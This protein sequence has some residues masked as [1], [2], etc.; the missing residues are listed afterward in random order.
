[1]I[2]AITLYAL[3][4][5]IL[6]CSQQEASILQYIN[7]TSEP[8]FW[9][10]TNAVE[11]CEGYNGSSTSHVTKCINN[12]AFFLDEDHE[13][14]IFFKEDFINISHNL[15]LSNTPYL[16]DTDPITSRHRF[17]TEKV[18]S[19]FHNIDSWF[20]QILKKS[21]LYTNPIKDNYLREIIIK[22]D[23][24]FSSVVTSKVDNSNSID[25]AIYLLDRITSQTD[26]SRVTLSLSG[27]LLYKINQQITFLTNIQQ[28]SCH[29]IGCNRT[30]FSSQVLTQ[31][32]YTLALSANLENSSNSNIAVLSRAMALLKQ[33]IDNDSFLAELS[34]ESGVDLKHI[35]DLSNLDLDKAPHYIRDFVIAFTS[36]LSKVSYMQAA[37]SYD[38]GKRTDISFGFAKDSLRQIQSSLA[39]YIN[40]NRFVL[41]QAKAER[42]D[43]LQRVQDNM[44]SHEARTILLNRQR[45]MLYE[46]S[47]KLSEME[48]IQSQVIEH[49]LL[50]NKYINDLKNLRVKIDGQEFSTLKHV[51]DINFTMSAQ[52]LK[53]DGDSNLNLISLKS[54]TNNTP[55]S[56]IYKMTVTGQ[57]SPICALKKNNFDI[58]DTLTG[59]EGYMLHHSRSESKIESVS[60]ANRTTKYQDNSQTSNLCIS[61]VYGTPLS[62]ISGSAVG[63]SAT[64]CINYSKGKRTEETQDNSS[65]N[66]NS[67]V[68]T[69]SFSRGLR[70]NHTP[71]KLAPAGSLLVA[72]TTAGQVYPDIAQNVQVVNRQHTII[73]GPGQTAYFFGNDCAAAEASS[74]PLNIS[75]A[76]YISEQEEVTSYLNA[77]FAVISSSSLKRKVEQ[78]I[79]KGVILPGEL[80]NLRATMFGILAEMQLDITPIQTL[81]RIFEMWISELLLQVERKAEIIQYEKDLK[82][83]TFELDRI[84]ASQSY[85]EKKLSIR[86]LLVN[87]LLQHSSLKY[88][89]NRF[90]KLSEF[91][92]RIVI[93]TISIHY[94]DIKLSHP[95]MDQLEKLSSLS[96]SSSF[97][98]IAY[99]YLHALELLKQELD[100]EK[101]MMILESENIQSATI[102]VA[103]PRPE[104]YSNENLRYDYTMP[105]ASFALSNSLWSVI[106]NEIEKNSISF[107]LNLRDL[108]QSDVADFRLTCSRSRVVV[109]NSVLVFAFD[110]S[111]ADINKIIRENSYN[112]SIDIVMG[113]EMNFV[114]KD[115]LE[116]YYI[117][118]RADAEIGISYGMGARLALDQELDIISLLNS[119]EHSH[120]GRGLS[121]FTNFTLK[122]LKGLNSYFS[123]ICGHAKCLDPSDIR[124]IYLAFSIKYQANIN[125]WIGCRE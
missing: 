84:E 116:T 44:D 89:E 16:I 28:L 124:T 51:G 17:I 29:L 10:M 46:I 90:Y 4:S 11:K 93:P 35:D 76:E 30:K 9:D 57:W 38:S 7:C 122:E 45:Q 114:N 26:E 53:Y 62:G 12:F 115:R 54:I 87:D 110:T 32:I 113:P 19:Y 5:F 111:D 64:A 43:F 107:H 102:A 88:I 34:E 52:D 50:M 39:T 120:A 31:Y 118:N 75:L 78:S 70:L 61:A 67:L 86:K 49:D 58:N 112:P 74:E 119:N 40:D 109:D 14:N 55:R 48:A 65:V 66:A 63:V 68:S 81:N 21:Q 121:P 85:N 101:S 83:L 97:V 91:V 95:L 108:Y 47:V 71:Y 23:D 60:H 82:N 73:L 27:H 77:M 96:I 123:V 100:Y 105:L 125:E 72:I 8:I 98:D 59:P 99:D 36:N 92:N 42:K 103:I 24:V 94:P 41:D 33:H 18:N 1:M 56:K 20:S 69:A 106:G 22:L 25:E 6:S 79:A 80:T 117:V 15:I 13:C 2:R 104:R 3:A 37:G